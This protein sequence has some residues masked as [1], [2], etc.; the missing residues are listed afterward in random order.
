MTFKSEYIPPLEQE[1]S[2]FFKSAREVL[3]TGYSKYDKWTIDREREM[4]LLFVAS[5]REPDSYNHDLW[6]FVDRKGYYSFSTDC[7]SRQETS[8]GVLSITYALGPFKCVGPFG[9]PDPA[10]LRC[11]K[12]ALR[13]YKDGEV[14][15]KY[16]TCELTLVD[17]RNGM[18]I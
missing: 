11:I 15:S 16:K 10:T 2:E 18:E 13:E 7:L 5:G 4:V 14:S 12:D 8:L 17:S 3:R 6:R 1:T 9:E